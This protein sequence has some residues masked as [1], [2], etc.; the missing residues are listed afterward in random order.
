M[1]KR[2]Y[3][4]FIDD[5]IRSIEIIEQYAKGLTFD[6]LDKNLEKQDAITR[7]LEII[8]EAVKNIP[9][10]T[11]IQFPQIPWKKIS[12]YEILLFTITLDSLLRESGKFLVKTFLNLKHRRYI[13]KIV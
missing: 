10:E 6:D 11:R 9:S 3:K 8:G 2:E 1:G 7:R 5:I 12:G 4:F 13:L